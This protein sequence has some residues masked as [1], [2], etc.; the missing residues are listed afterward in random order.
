[1]GT[2]AAQNAISADKPAC[3]VNPG[4]LLTKPTLS[5]RC[6]Q[7]CTAAS[8]DLLQQAVAKPPPYCLVVDGKLFS[9]QNTTQDVFTLV[10][11]TKLPSSVSH[12]EGLP[13]IGLSMQLKA[14]EFTAVPS[15]SIKS[16]VSLNMD[17]N[18]ITSL[19]SAAAA[20]PWQGTPNITTLYAHMATDPPNPLSP[21][22]LQHN[23]LTQVN[24]TA[25]PP[26][27]SFVCLGGN[28][29]TLIAAS[30]AAFEVLKKLSQPHANAGH[31]SSTC[32]DS[33]PF[34]S[35][36]LPTPQCPPPT[37]LETLWGV[38]PICVTPPTTSSSPDGTKS[39][40]SVVVVS[41]ALALIMLLLLA[42]C[43][44]RRRARLSPNWY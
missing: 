34:A 30:S 13:S 26:S 6:E 15:L 35:P 43:I 10:D 32:D 37:K 7:L 2:T 31:A 24:F 20:G 9:A 29:L 23:A 4:A 14:N 28:N 44:Q 27:L 42:I 17:S 8:L 5:S 16:L 12:I 19:T 40:A 11:V 25:L 33:T 36:N 3:D 38:Y 41:V 22:N 39:G 1:M 21:L 18:A